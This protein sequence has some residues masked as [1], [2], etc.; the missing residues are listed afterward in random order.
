MELNG[1]TVLI[2][3]ASSGIGAA[4]AIQAA[5]Q[6]A[7]LILMARR[8]QKLQ[9]VAEQC[10]TLT[11]GT[12]HYVTLDVTDH[13]AVAQYVAQAPQV[14]VLIANAGYGLFKAATEFSFDEMEQMFRVNALA[15]MQFANAFAQQMS[16]R[17]SGHIVLVASQ[18]GKV[19]TPKSAVYSATKSAVIS[20]ANALRLELKPHR[21]AV[22]TINPGP[23]ATEFFDHADQEGSYLDRLQHLVLPTAYV[24]Q[25]IV[26]VIGTSRREVNIPRSMAIASKL[27]A[28]CPT[29]GDALTL[30]FF[31]KK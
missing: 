31:N 26:A 9:Q 18:A 14:D 13:H 17:Q 15:M 1:K 23:V 10:Q 6:Q 27:Y 21:V 5:E 29:V 4:V 22:T 16:A 24:A 30:K 12:V 20:Y 25:R 28:L 3:G 7:N 19:A 8:T 11:S 2:T